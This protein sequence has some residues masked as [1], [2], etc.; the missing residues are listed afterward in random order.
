MKRFLMIVASLVMVLCTVR[1]AAAALIPGGGSGPGGSPGSGGGGPGD[2]L[3]S[4][5]YSDTSGNTGFG[6]LNAVPDGLGDG[7][8]LAVSGSITITGGG[9]AG[10]TLS[11]LSAGPGVTAID[12][13]IVDNLVYPNNNAGNGA[14]NGQGG[15]GFIGNP[16]FLDNGGIIFGG[17]GVT[18]NIWGNGGGDYAFIYDQNGAIGGANSGGTFTVVPE[19]ASLTLFG[20]GAVSLIGFARRQRKRTVA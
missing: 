9:L 1:P 16:S 15:L 14:N 7:G 8:L 4:F 19:P 11:L 13:F 20:L 6:S 10:D 2:P 18:L 17:A 3:I 5:T 12:I